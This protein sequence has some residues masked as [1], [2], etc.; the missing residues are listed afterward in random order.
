MNLPLIT[1]ILP[2]YKSQLSGNLAKWCL[3][4]K[5]VCSGSAIW[6]RTM[7]FHLSSFFP[8][9]CKENGSQQKKL[10]VANILICPTYY[11]FGGAGGTIFYFALPKKGNLS[12]SLYRLYSLIRTE[13]VVFFPSFWRGLLV[14]AQINTTLYSL[15]SSGRVTKCFLVRN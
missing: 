11:C 10:L 13:N 5:C 1:R 3:T 8:R 6:N 7:V 14:T 2:S 12:L 9:E 15:S 4:R